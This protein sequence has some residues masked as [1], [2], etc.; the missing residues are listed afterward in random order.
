VT[1]A[2]GRVA[3][4]SVPVVP[5]APPADT[6]LVLKSTDKRDCDCG[7]RLLPAVDAASG[8]TAQPDVMNGVLRVRVECTDCGTENIFC[9]S[10]PINS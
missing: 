7:G 4:A 6:S 10:V 8:K 2:D 9:C 5:F 3:V 1:S